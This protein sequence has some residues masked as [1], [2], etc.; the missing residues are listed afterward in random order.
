MKRLAVTGLL[1]LL[2]FPQESRAAQDSVLWL[3]DNL[4]SIGG[5]EVR[6]EGDPRVI[7]T[8]HGKAIE[9]DGI[10]DGIFLDVHP[11]AGKTEFTA[12]VIFKPYADGAPEQ[13]FFHM[14]EDDSESRV[15]F[16]TRLPGDGEWFLDTFIKSDEKGTTLY[17]SDHLHKTVAWQHAAI[18]VDGD[19]FRHYV[20]GRLELEETI[21][22][23]AQGPG[24]T[25]LGVRL[26]KVHWFRGAISKA[27]FT[28]RALDPG[29]FDRLAG[30]EVTIS[31]TETRSLYSQIVGQEYSLQISLPSGYGESD[32]RYPVVYLLDAQ[33]DF[34][35]I[36]SI[37]GE[38]YYDGFLPEMILVGVTWGGD[39]PDHDVLRLR[40]FTPT[41]VHGNGESGGAG[42]FLSFFEKELIPWVD[43][44]YRASD[45]RTLVGSSLGGLFTLYTLFNRPDLF[46]NYIPTSPATQWDNGAVYRYAEGFSERSSQHPSRLFVAVAE[47]EGLYP[48]VMKLVDSLRE[49]NYPGLTWTSHVVTGAGH[50]GVKPEGNTRGLQYVFERPDLVLTKAE[51]EP[52]LG[53]WRSTD[54]EVEVLIDTRDGKLHA[55]VPGEG[56]S[57][58]M[59]AADKTHFYHRGS[60]L[61]VRFM[62][63]E[64]GTPASFIAQTYGTTREYHKD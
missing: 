55:Q 62:P 34:P 8:P 54:G 39:D 25:S 42:K 45:S 47:L 4:E 13:R 17:A 12:E 63:A 24:K 14:Q 52:Y 40:D 44:H 18:V 9:F 58:L 36:Y 23:E 28:P 22:F 26:N 19:S 50:S 29:E 33:W 43:Q 20:N 53:I 15:M 35:L 38:Q 60:F 2:A 31:G 7:E 56:E 30:P 21:E 57:W 37:Y 27:R 51:L 61:K 32:Q 64:N 11:L 49:A 46:D 3:L 41:D 48:T 16:E 59:N 5:H 1:V 6:V 10:D